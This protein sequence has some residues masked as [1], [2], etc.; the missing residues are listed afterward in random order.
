MSAASK[1]PPRL[2]C[3]ACSGIIRR[4]PRSAEDRDAALHPSLRRYRCTRPACAWQ[5]LLPR[6]HGLQARRRPR[7]PATSTALAAP[8]ATLA[9][10]RWSWKLVPV[11]AAGLVAGALAALSIKGLAGSPTAL[12]LAPGVHHEGVGLAASH[13]LLQAPE[14]AGPEVE[15]LALKQGCAWAQ[16]GRSPYRGSVEQALVTARLPAEVVQRIVLKVQAGQPDD[17]LLIGNAG[18]RARRDAREFDAGNVAMT[19]ARTLCVNTRVNFKPGHTEAASLY[20][21]A[22]QQGRLHSVMVPDVCGNVSV[23]GVRMERRRAQALPVLAETTHG[24]VPVLHTLW[25]P[26]EDPPR[27]VP[28]PGTLANVLLALAAAALARRRRGPGETV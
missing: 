21:A 28:A 7:G 25:L 11:L 4:T 17:R 23:L 9:T 27:A 19:Y 15:R 16:P 12:T 3:P 22:D 5:G 1:E 2:T 18:I 8:A 26:E 13:P 10:A 20:E 14:T 6:Q 24:A